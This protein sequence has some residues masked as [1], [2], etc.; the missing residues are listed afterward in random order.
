MTE[1]RVL[2]GHAAKRLR[3][4][5]ALDPLLSIPQRDAETRRKAGPWKTSLTRRR[6]V[7]GRPGIKQSEISKHPEVFKWIPSS[8]CVHLEDMVP[9]SASGL[10]ISK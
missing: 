4:G 1:F 2:P 7:S 6:E 3:I 8:E 5:E 10:C 9:I